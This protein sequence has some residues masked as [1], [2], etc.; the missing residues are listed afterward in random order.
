VIRN[1]RCSMRD[2]A[3]GRA[4]WLA[5]GQVPRS[6]LSYGWAGERGAEGAE[7]S[8]CSLL[9]RAVR[10]T[11]PRK[12]PSRTQVPPPHWWLACASAAR[13]SP[14]APAHPPPS[15]KLLGFGFPP[16]SLAALKASPS[17]RP[18]ARLLPPPF[19]S[20]REP[21]PW[22]RGMRCRWCRGWGR[23]CAMTSV[24]PCH[25]PAVGRS[26]TAR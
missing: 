14:L 8:A 10:F 24:C 26:S 13:P 15:V 21:P 9:G 18:L 19:T 1:K 12:E 6:A 22:W 3:N 16:H 5:L 25:R 4:A 23:G 20:T 2:P 17:A 7:G 11:K